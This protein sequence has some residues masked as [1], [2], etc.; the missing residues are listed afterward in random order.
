MRE[1]NNYIICS[2]PKKEKKLKK[3]MA[4]IYVLAT[5]EF[6]SED[7]DQVCAIFLLGGK[8]TSIVVLG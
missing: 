8:A 5:K 6:F 4:D 3:D 7:N 2:N 1:C